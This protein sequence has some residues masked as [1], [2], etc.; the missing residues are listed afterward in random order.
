MVICDKRKCIFVHIPK[1]GGTTVEKRLG[2]T[3][4]ENLYSTT[5][6]ENNRTLQHMSAQKLREKYPEKFET[7][8]TFSIVRNPYTRFL[9]SYM[10]FPAMAGMG[11]LA[12]QTLD[13]FIET[14]S[15]HVLTKEF[16]KTPF[17]EHI[18]PQYQ[19]IYDQIDNLIVDHLFHMEKYDKVDAFLIQKFQCYDTTIYERGP[20]KPLL[21]EQQ[22]KKIAILY[23]KDFELLGYE[24]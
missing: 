1:T 21:T 22:K 3:N 5:L 20:A 24:Q 11:H 6:F 10:W 18:I 8:C 2:L 19:Y 17:H 15:W 23:K 7:Y 4:I 16:S 9:S 13:E 14:A 12:G